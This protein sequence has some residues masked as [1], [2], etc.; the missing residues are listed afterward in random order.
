MEALMLNRGF[1]LFRKELK[2]MKIKPG[3]LYHI[4][5]E[6]FK[7]VDD[8]KLMRNKPNGGGRPTLICKVKG[9]EFLW[10]I[11]ISSNIDKYK[12]LLKESQ[13]KI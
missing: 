1:L 6:F 5:D 3:Y 12:D 8:D 9:S 10:A 11:P 7:V 13:E 4:K 2:S